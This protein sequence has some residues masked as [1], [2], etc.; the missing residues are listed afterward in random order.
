[1]LHGPE[2]QISVN[3][4]SEIFH[5]KVFFAISNSNQL[6]ARE[7]FEALASNKH[8]AAMMKLLNWDRQAELQAHVAFTVAAKKN[9][10]MNII[11][12]PNSQTIM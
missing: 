11:T 9:P 5:R 10:T 3:E 2:P 7:H 1:L 12:I 8:D 4:H 6:K